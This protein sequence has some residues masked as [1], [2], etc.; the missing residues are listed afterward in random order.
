MGQLLLEHFHGA[1]TRVGATDTA[2]PLRAE[3][4]HLLVL[5]QWTDPGDNDARIA[6][7]RN[8]YSAM[9]P[10]LGSGRYLNCLGGDEVVAAYGPNYRR[11]QQLKAKYDPDNFFRLN[12]NVSPMA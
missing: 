3:G 1:I 12:Q 6:W 2:F 5:S 11:L 9:Q 8:S 10:F 7:A 4:Y